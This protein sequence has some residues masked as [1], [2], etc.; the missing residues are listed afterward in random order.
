MDRTILDPINAV[1]VSL[2]QSLDGCAGKSP[3]L[4][5]ADAVR[6]RDKFQK[7]AD[8]FPKNPEARPVEKLLEL[9][10]SLEPI[11]VQ[12]LARLID[13]WRLFMNDQA[14]PEDIL[15]PDFNFDL[16]NAFYSS[17]S[18]YRQYHELTLQA[19]RLVSLK[20]GGRPLRMIELGS[21]TGSTTRLVLD[22]HSE[23]RIAE[24]W[25][26]DVSPSLVKALKHQFKDATQSIQYQTVNLDKAWNGP[27]DFDVAFAVNVVHATQ[28]LD[29]TLGQL[30][31]MIRPGGYLVLGEIAPVP[32]Y[33]NLLMELSFGALPSFFNKSDRHRS[34]TPLMPLKQWRSILLEQEW[35]EV[36]CLPETEMDHPFWGG[37]IIAKKENA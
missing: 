14:V 20:L 10:P 16:V 27:S 11:H 29:H 33:G 26:T 31:K 35:R 19:L 4:R 17:S 8:F 7:M 22:P 15:F 25:C 37:A 23:I 24:F 1:L 9:A 36:E 2:I 12:F 34:Q 5:S 18:I 28:D 6:L 13:G 30:K 21:G 32:E 3:E